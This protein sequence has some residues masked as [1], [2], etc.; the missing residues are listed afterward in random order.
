MQPIKR[1][2]PELTRQRLADPLIDVPFHER[3]EIARAVDLRNNVGIELLPGGYV[4]AVPLNS[5]VRWGD[6]V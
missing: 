2:V 3:L 4:R 6:T 5:E 1:R